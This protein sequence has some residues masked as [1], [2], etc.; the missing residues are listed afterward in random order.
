MTIS[1]DPPQISRICFSSLIWMFQWSG[2]CCNQ[3]IIIGFEFF[4]ISKCFRTD[5]SCNLSSFV[6]CHSLI[7]KLSFCKFLSSC[8]K[9]ILDILEKLSRPDVNAL[10]HELGFQV[11]WDLGIWVSFLFQCILRRLLQFAFCSSFMNYV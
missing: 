9:I 2:Q 10:L 11:S 4:Q 8:L 1:I 3:N 6:F 5:N 7:D